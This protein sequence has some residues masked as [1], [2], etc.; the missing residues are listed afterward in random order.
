M[1]F[2]WMVAFIVL[3]FL[4]W[5]FGAEMLRDFIFYGSNNWDFSKTRES[6]IYYGYLGRELISGHGTVSV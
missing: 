1:T 6:N 3:V 5:V 2:E 4:I